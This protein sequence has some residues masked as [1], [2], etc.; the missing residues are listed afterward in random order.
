MEKLEKEFIKSLDDYKKPGYDNYRIEYIGEYG[1]LK[2]S[3]KEII[4]YLAVK[5]GQELK[6]NEDEVKAL[7]D[8]FYKLTE[9]K[10]RVVKEKVNNKVSKTLVIEVYTKSI[11]DI[12]TPLASDEEKKC[13]IPI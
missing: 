3:W 4:A 9:V 11:E 1:S 10:T 8:I 7:R 5:F 12:M 6:G 13:S 2:I